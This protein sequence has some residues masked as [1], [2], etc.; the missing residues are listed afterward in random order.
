MRFVY[1]IVC[2]ISDNTTDNSSDRIAIDLYCVKS[3]YLL[4]STAWIDTIH[5]IKSGCIDH[6]YII[7]EWLDNKNIHEKQ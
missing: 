1:I 3:Q 5:W 4:T 2:L 6:E 7:Q